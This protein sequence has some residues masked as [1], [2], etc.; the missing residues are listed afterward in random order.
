MRVPQTRVLGG[1]KFVYSS[2]G[3]AFST[4]LAFWALPYMREA[5]RS[6]QQSKTFMLP[7]KGL[8]LWCKRLFTSICLRVGLEEPLEELALAVYPASAVPGGGTVPTES[9]LAYSL[10]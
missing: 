3:H 4:L 7:L 5:D 9:C 1:T 8:S 2:A 10:G 6:K